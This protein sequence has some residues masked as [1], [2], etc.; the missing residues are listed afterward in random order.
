M[1]AR[2]LFAL[3]GLAALLGKE[4][5]VRSVA[6]PYFLWHELPFREAWTWLN[7][8]AILAGI[9]VSNNVHQ[10]NGTAVWVVFLVQWFA[11]FFRLSFPVFALWKSLRRRWPGRG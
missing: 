4:W 10:P 9:I 3:I 5:L 11:L 7:M 6:A 1:I 8:P 2:S